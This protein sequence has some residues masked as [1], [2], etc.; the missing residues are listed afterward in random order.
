MYQL[1]WTSP[2]Q[3]PEEGEGE[4]D[5][6]AEAETEQTETEQTDGE[7]G[8]SASPVEQP[9]S[10]VIVEDLPQST[11]NIANMMVRGCG[12]TIALS[13]AFLGRYPLP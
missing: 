3:K 10:R 8:E 11:A 2:S 7:A 9:P 12:I 4:T 1:I 13:K 5:K 6:P